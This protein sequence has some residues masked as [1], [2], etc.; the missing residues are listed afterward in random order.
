VQINDN[1]LEQYTK[2]NKNA[3]SVSK[4]ELLSTHAENMNKRR[5]N[6]GKKHNISIHQFDEQT[7]KTIQETLEKERNNQ[8]LEE[9]A[10]LS[11]S[12]QVPKTEPLIKI[13]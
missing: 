5:K 7:Q 4:P 1:Y 9:D 13:D 10:A 2:G 3:S 11:K 12:V 6:K 8:K